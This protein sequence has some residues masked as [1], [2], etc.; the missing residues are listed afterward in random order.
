MYYNDTHGM[1]VRI[2][3]PLIRVEIEHTWGESYEI[4]F[5]RRVYGYRRVENQ[6][7]RYTVSADRAQRL[8]RYLEHHKKL[9]RT[10]DV[11][12]VFEPNRLSIV[13]LFG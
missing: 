5:V 8:V 13:I 11:R 1:S 6:E 9:G 3:G 4:R 2:G 10:I 7:T 12:P